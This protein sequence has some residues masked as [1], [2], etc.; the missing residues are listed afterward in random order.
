MVPLRQARSERRRRAARR[1]EQR[2]PAF[3]RDEGS[4][5]IRGRMSRT[6]TQE[7]FSLFA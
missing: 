5:I 2:A 3:G 6:E 4:A 1:A 7:I